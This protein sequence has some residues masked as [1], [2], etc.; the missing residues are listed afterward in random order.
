[1]NAIVPVST[2]LLPEYMRSHWSASKQQT[3]Y[4]FEASTKMRE[5]GFPVPT[6]PLGTNLRT[7]LA[8]Y[9]REL[10]PVLQGW[11]DRSAI[12]V[13]AGP[14]YMTMDWALERYEQT[15]Q[16]RNT[17]EVTQINNRY[18]A[19]R[20]CRHVM[21]AGPWAGIRFGCI[22]VPE[23]TT[24]LADQL[25]EEY[26]YTKTHADG[27]TVREKR[28][29]VARNDMHI[30]TTMLNAIER[31]YEDLFYKGANPFAGLRTWHKAKGPRGANLAE[32]AAFVRTADAMNL[33]SVSAIVLYAWEFH[34]RVSHFPYSARVEDYRSKFHEDEIFVRAE[35]VDDERYFS[36]VNDDGELLFPAL[37]ERLDEMTEKRATGPLFVW[38]ESPAG[39]PEPWPL[40][41]LQETVVEICEKA[42]MDR[43]TLRQ[44][45]KGGLTESGNAGLTTTEIMSI[46]MHKT[47]QT[48][49]IYT[50]KNQAVA[51]EAQEKRLRF[52][53]KKL[54]RGKDVTVL[55][56]A[57]PD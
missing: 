46:S 44:F 22:P 32:L 37:T 24:A 19:L 48:V 34:A 41:R 31:K 52:R 47:E 49:Q 21:Q 9:E 43:L 16:F 56:T 25:Y 27:S 8:R 11:W 1:M 10:L 14:A 57:A 39:R 20:C 3:F 28:S 50:E 55:G 7:A 26:L 4:R 5:A 6:M 38:E 33:R 29:R 23:I 54:K 42:G 40:K 17:R 2:D 13:E 51:A 30:L 35:K 45:R 12:V 53:Q 15:L 36:L 18:G